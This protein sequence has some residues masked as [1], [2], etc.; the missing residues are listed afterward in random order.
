M[1]ARPT[2][3]T[4]TPT[5]DARLQALIAWLTPQAT[6]YTL[7]LETIR[8]AS[9]DASFRRYFRLECEGGPHASLIAMDAP[10]PHETIGPFVSIAQLF[11]DAGLNAPRVLAHDAAQ[12]FVLLTDLGQTTYLNALLD[13]QIR[14][15]MTRAHALMI[16]A[17]DALVRWQAAS[18]PG[19][20]PPYDAA[21]LNKE[22]ALFPDW[23]IGQH[24]GLALNATQRETLARVLKQIVATNVAQG[25]VYVH[26][27]YMPRNLMCTTPNPG[28]LDFQDAVFG[29][30]SYDIASLMRDAFI[31]WNE[32][33]VL[34]WA[35]RYWERARAASL[36]VPSDF[37]HFWRDVEW[38]GLQRHLKVLGIFAR[39]QYRDG[40]PQYLADSPRFVRYVRDV[41][42]RYDTLAPLA[43]LLDDLEGTPKT[44][45]TTF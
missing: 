37:G 20:L 25:L 31:S 9:A 17:I 19:V 21:L 13:T 32:D 28:I 29:P 8:P 40:K 4:D 3:D 1:I 30:I 36:P 33:Q 27:D 38:M 45:A 18:R 23:Y 42:Q 14:H 5:K 10:P 35:I 34:D 24:L 6:Q 2:P 26:R 39:I 41:A 12:G 11:L 43:H 16:D 44:V 7:A 22:L 15:D